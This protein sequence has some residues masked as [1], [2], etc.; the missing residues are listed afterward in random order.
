MQDELTEL[1]KIIKKRRKSDP[2]SSYVAKL[3]HKGRG[4]ISQKVGEEAVEVVIEA[5]SGKR[6]GVIAESADLM[7]HLLVLWAEM[8][9]SPK[10]VVEELVK[11]KGTSGLEEKENR[12][13]K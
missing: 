2:K 4:K 13:D 12:K 10:D 8:G 9:V 7:F 5:I 11:R 3:F 6:K 1:Y